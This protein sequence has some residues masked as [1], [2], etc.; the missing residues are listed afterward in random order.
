[1]KGGCVGTCVY[2][3]VFVCSVVY[4]YACLCDFWLHYNFLIQAMFELLM[5][6]SLVKSLT[7]AKENKY[8][9]LHKTSET[10][11]TEM[12]RQKEKLQLLWSVVQKIEKEGITQHPL[13]DSLTAQI[14]TRLKRVQQEEPTLTVT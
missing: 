1:M 10:R 6:Q 7:A 14:T 9:M 11:L 4:M 5:T 13:L 12:Q 2:V 8:R 3:C